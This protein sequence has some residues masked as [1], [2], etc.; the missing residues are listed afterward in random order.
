MMIQNFFTDGEKY[1]NTKPYPYTFIDN[2]LS[3]DVAKELQT[4]ILSL[5]KAMFDRYDNPFEQKY[6]LRDKFNYPE[7]L[8]SLMEY[9][10]SEPFVKQLSEY[11]AHE[12]LIDEHR[13]YWGVHIYEPGDKLDIH[14]DAGFHPITNQKKQVTLG[15]YLSY[16]W[17]DTYGC[18][19]EIWEGDKASDTNP[20]LRECVAKIAPM[21]NRMILF[22]CTD[23]SWH[24]NPV[25][26]C[27]PIGSKRVFVTISYLSN[28]TD[29]SN[30][31]KKAYFIAR[32]DDPEDEA[33]DKLR[34]IRA[35]HTKCDTVYRTMM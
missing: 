18:D 15:I 19:L 13:M 22:D 14:V 9:L 17:E 12:L 4:E 6:T 16:D 11:T 20:K 31:L 1:R 21:F 23:N 29:Y 7:R 3:E 27:S 30:K 24:G 28:E 10:T 8:K 2:A 26:S 33:K 34:A 25:P 35:D 5:P 32:P